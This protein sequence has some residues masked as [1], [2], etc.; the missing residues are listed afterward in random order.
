MLSDLMP[1]AVTHILVPIIFMD[2]FR[3]YVLRKR[4]II[5]NKHVLLAGLAGL[6][7]DI[8]IPVGFLFLKR[9]VHRLYTHNIWIPVLFLAISIYLHFIRKKKL[10]RYFIMISF[11]FLA[12]LLLDSF[13]AGTI[14]PFYP[15]STYE[16][17]LNIVPK[18]MMI[19]VPSL[20]QNQQFGYLI[21]SSLDALLLFFWLIYLQMT[22]KIR[23]Y[24]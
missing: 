21:F 4:G 1:L 19:F 12:H 22:N 8:D 5:T 2:L 9:N 15:F 13:L 24:F 3:D 16:F 17:G 20:V 11:G 18:L 10:S 6:F 23:D 14:R 7:P